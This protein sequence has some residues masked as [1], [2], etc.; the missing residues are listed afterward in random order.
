M[1]KSNLIR[2]NNYKSCISA[3]NFEAARIVYPNSI[4]CRTG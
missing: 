2:D 3:F 4:V 1:K